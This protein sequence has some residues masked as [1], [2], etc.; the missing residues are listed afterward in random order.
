MDWQPIETAPSATYIIAAVVKDGRVLHAEMTNIC[1]SDDGD[2]EWDGWTDVPPTH[3]I[4]VPEFK[5]S[6]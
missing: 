4:P 3:W 1:Y 2:I 6:T 5:Q